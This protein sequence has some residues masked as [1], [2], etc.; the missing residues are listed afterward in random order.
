MSLILFLQYY[1][2]QKQP[3]SGEYLR[4]FDILKIKPEFIFEN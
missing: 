3:K 1:C 4:I 2:K